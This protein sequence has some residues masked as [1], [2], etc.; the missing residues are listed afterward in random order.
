M[1]SP[2]RAGAPGATVTGMSNDPIHKVFVAGASGAIGRRLVPMLLERGYAVAA[3]TRH[4]D[5]A[6]ALG[7]LGAEPV[8]AD[9]LDRNAVLKAVMRAE[10]DAVIH[11]MTALDGVTSI[12]RFDSAFAMTNRLRS[13]GTDHLLEAARAAGAHRFIAQSYGNWGYDP[14][15]SRVAR[16]S[17]PL[18]PEPPA[19]QRRSFAAV[20]HLEHAVL[21]AEGLTGIVLR[22]GSFYGPG[23]ALATDGAI[24]P[25]V[26]KRRFPI[27]GD[28]GGV[29]SF[30]HVDDAAAAT[31]AALEHGE[32]GIYYVVDDDPAPV[33][34]WLPELARVLGAKPP[35]H[36]PLWLGRLVGGEVGVEMMTRSHGASNA[37]AKRELGWQPVYASWRE[38]FRHGLTE[39]LLSELA[40]H[41]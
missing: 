6:V 37:K 12:R 38:G 26:R 4:R 33:S 3:M 13:E 19:R 27:I 1:I 10:P 17:D 11:E 39:S 25:L 35:R 8:V 31:V 22:Y 15:G 20:R 24:T 40:D 16:E 2:V 21:Q 14:R 29:V 7:A 34:A 18:N 41:A 28:G 9:A 5:N 23:T 36:V 30:I 32:A